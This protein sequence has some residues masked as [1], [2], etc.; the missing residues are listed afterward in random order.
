[1]G[2]DLKPVDIE[3]FWRD[4]ALAH[5][6]NC[7]SK[8]APQVA[9]GIRM[10]DECVFAE[11]N[12]PGNPWGTTPRERRLD[13]NKRYN[14]LA[15]QIVGKRLLSEK[16]PE[17]DEIFPKFRQIGEVFEGTYQNNGI[18]VWLHGNC[19]TP[20]ELERML[21]RVDR[22]NIQ[23]FILPGN[24]ETEKRRIFEQYGK[25][26]SVWRHVRGPVTLATSIYGTE[27]TLLLY[28]DAPELF[29]RF[30]QT[31]LRVIQ[32]YIRIF[33][34]EAGFTPQTAPHG[35]SFLMMIVVC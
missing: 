27:N 10:S 23:E 28:Y 16:L 3:R 19:R 31:I 5:E 4:D 13:L 29:E 30:S 14:D 21:D 35:F 11:L 17:A 7:F 32:E 6:D 24:W 1:M 22:L 25:R 33:D 20:K 12:E 26:P 2:K 8:L 34:E 9:L 15:E 18:T